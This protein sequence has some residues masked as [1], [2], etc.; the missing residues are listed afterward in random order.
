M[1][2][3]QSATVDADPAGNGD[4]ATL[5]K[6]AVFLTVVR[7]AGPRL[8]EASLIPSALFYCCLVTIGIGAAYA[9]ALLWIY[10][11]I[12]TRAVRHRPVPP[13]LVIGAIALSARTALAVASDST[14]LYFVEPVFGSMVIGCVFLLSIAIGRPMVKRLA[15]VFWPLTPE[16]LA[17]PVVDRL[18]RRLTYLWAG[19]NFA[20]G[21]VTFTLL[22]L[23]PLPLFVALKQAVAWT[24]AGV[25]IAI[26]IDRAVRTAHRTGFIA[27]TQTAMRARAAA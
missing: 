17:H 11:G 15:L 4:D 26:T 25:G 10:A 21:A 24:I 9:A 23:L 12:A 6:V 1:V 22:V 3:V 7:H 19:V 18:L 20:T 2:S 14:F 5:S 8:I 16:M 27:A 13:L